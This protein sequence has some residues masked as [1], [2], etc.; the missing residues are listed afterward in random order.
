MAYPL[1]EL[2]APIRTARGVGNLVSFIAG[3][4]SVSRMERGWALE[5]DKTGKT[6][7]T[8]WLLSMAC[9]F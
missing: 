9:L 3:T 1:M 4:S 6:I 5:G 2:V 7:Q 8:A